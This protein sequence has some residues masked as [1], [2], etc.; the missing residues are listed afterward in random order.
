MKTT[1]STY[2]TGRDTSSIVAILAEDGT[3]LYR[4]E[5]VGTGAHERARACQ[6]Q[7]D[8]GKYEAAQFQNQ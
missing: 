1:L 2:G 5:F 3:E 7:W 8:Q 6:A 4:M